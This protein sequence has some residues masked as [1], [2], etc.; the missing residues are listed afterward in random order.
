M[1]III[2]VNPTKP[3]VGSPV[4]ADNTPVASADTILS[5][6]PDNVF[7]VTPVVVNDKASTLLTLIVPVL[8]L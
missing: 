8:P 7:T 3:P 1:C 2:S 4:A 6:V 5:P